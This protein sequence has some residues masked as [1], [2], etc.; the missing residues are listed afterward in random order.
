MSKRDRYNI[1]KDILEIVYD[2]ETLYRNQMNQTQVGYNANLTN[3]QSVKYL[4]GLANLGLLVLADFKPF[5]YYE[6]K[7]KGWRCL[8][9]FAEIE[10]D[11]RPVTFA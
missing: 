1:V 10:D 6:I 2:T 5:P 9:V 11:L 4:R 3:S 8:Q 7:S